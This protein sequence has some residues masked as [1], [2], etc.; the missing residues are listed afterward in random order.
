M[1]ISLEARTSIIE[2]VLGMFG[3]APGVNVLAALVASY[4]AGSSISQIAQNLANT[5][6]FKT[7]YPSFLSDQEY[8]ARIVANLAG[9]EVAD[10][11]KLAATTLLQ[12]MLTAGQSRTDVLLAA[13]TAVSAITSQNASWANVGAAFD[14]KLS[15]AVYY[16]IAKQLSGASLAGLQSIVANVTSAASTVVAAK[17][18]IDGKAVVANT[19]TLTSSTDNLT[20][21]VG[22]DIFLANT[23]INQSTG[24]V[25][26][27]TLSALDV[28]IG[29]SGNDTLLYSTVG[30]DAFPGATIRQIESLIIASDGEVTANL[31]GSN[32]S[33]ITSVTATAIGGDVNVD[34]NS[35][36]TTVTILGTASGVSI[37]DEGDA[38]TGAADDLASVS[39]TGATGDITIATDTLTAL[40]LNSTT[41]GDVAVNSSSGTR[42]LTI[43]L[44]N[45]SGPA[46]DVV[47]TDNQAT[48]VV[49]KST[50]QRSSAVDLQMDSATNLAF[51]AD[52]PVTI[53]NI[54][55]SAA[56]TIVLTGDSLVTIE[57]VEDFAAVTSISSLNSTGGVSIA[58]A[59]PTG[60][61]FVGGAGADTIVLTPGTTKVSSMGQ[62][63]DTVTLSGVFGTG[64]SVDAGAG[65]DTLSMTAADAASLSATGLFEATINGFE[66]VHIGTVGAGAT[67]LVQLA[68]LDDINY[69]IS[70]GTTAPTGGSSETAT[71]VFSALKIGQSASAGGMT[72][73]ATTDLSAAALALAFSGATVAG[74]TVTGALSGYSAAAPSGTGLN[75]VVLTSTTP[76]NVVN[77]D[78]TPPSVTSI[79]AP[80]APVVTTVQGATAVTESSVLV[81]GTLA[82]TE[83]VTV[84]GRT[85]TATGTTEAAVVTVGA[86]TQGQTLTIAG[87][88]LTMSNTA[89][90]NAT[91][92]QVAAILI[93]GTGVATAQGSITVSGALTGYSVAAGTG[94]QV[95][96]TSTVTFSDVA[97]LTVSGTGSAASLATA[98]SITQGNNG[99]LT[100]TQVASAISTG[101]SSGAALVSGTL[102]LTKFTA[103]T[104]SANSVTFTSATAGAVTDIVVSSTGAMPTITTTQ[105]VTEA[106]ESASVVM[107]GLK[108]G[109]S[110]TIH[111]LTLTATGADLSAAQVA[112][113]L[114]GDTAGFA[115][116]ALTPLA[117]AVLTGS[118]AAGFAPAA[119]STGNTVVYTHPSVG[120]QTDIAT[121]VANIVDATA[122]V[123]TISE[124]GV[125]A[126]GGTT[127]TATV[128]FS[129]LRIGQS[130]S[131]GGM[132]V[133][134][135]TDL[136]AAALAS[137]FSGVTVTGATVT[138]ALSGYSAAAP[139][140]A[141]L[142]TVVFTSATPG[143]VVNFDNTPPSVTSIAAPVAPV[144][145]TVQGATAV[146]ESSA[147]VFGTLARTEAVTVNGRTITATGTTE[148]A[149]VTVG[150]L[151]QGQ[152]LTI[153]GRTLTMSNTAGDNATAAQVAAILIS[154]T[155]AATAQ[156]SITVS[157]AL[158]GYSAAA[159]SGTQ[160]VFT[161]TVTFSDVADLTVSGTGSAASLATAVSITQGNNGTLTGTQVASAVSTGTSSGAA[162]VSGTLDLTKFTA[163]TSSANNVTFTSATAGAVTDI[164][165]SSTGAMPTITT[166]QGVTASV[167][168][169]SVVMS[170]L[171]AGQSVTIHGL[172]LTATGADLSA[173]QVAEALDG[174]TAGF[175][176]SALTPLATA[177]LTGSYAAGFAP[178]A[179]STGN[180][181]V[182]THPSVGAQTDIATS[183]ANIADATAPVVTISEGGV[184]APAAGNLNL[185]GFG[186][187]G[188][189]ELKGAINGTAT[190]TLANSIGATDVFNLVLNGPDQIEN[191]GMLT[192]AGVE[193]VRISAGDSNADAPTN[194][195]SGASKV[196]LALADTTRIIVTGNHGIDFT[197]S[198]LPNLVNLDASGVVSV[199]DAPGATDAAIAATGKVT[200]TSTVT[201]KAVSVAT[202][203]GADEIN[204]S[205]ITNVAL[206]TSAATVATI[207]AGA[208]NDVITGSAGNDVISGGAGADFIKG[209]EGADTLSGGSGFDTFQ[210]TSAVESTLI[211]SDQITDFVANTYGNGASGAAGTGAGNVLLRT[212]D[213]LQFRV[214]ADAKA[215]GV[216]TFVGT[217]AA[218][219]LSFIQAAAIDPAPAK[220]NAFV[221]ALDSS[222]GRLYID[223]NSDGSADSVILLSGVVTITAAAFELIL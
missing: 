94:T 12:S 135:T 51:N 180:T 222:T 192:I 17:A 132:T 15:V 100:G 70:D 220:D 182:Y 134:A 41:D 65:V 36:V 184:G 128:V 127:E 6:E 33:G 82:R 19:Y 86:L 27:E 108:A 219:A 40:T 155:G 151:T 130:A 136:S 189:L 109:Q 178:A 50:G 88:T 195:P 73:T 199:G 148:A 202:G 30:G 95:V 111:G 47:I 123:V 167:E 25:D 5:S 22:D 183:V 113:A 66:K 74:A 39:I 209:G 206:V 179:I 200:F 56:Q 110:V 58:S 11:E 3:A 133:T 101:T 72:V 18:A 191:T 172:T 10:A 99:T 124:G 168:S 170:G 196:N 64:G 71:V 158:T 44:N 112:E 118:Y 139:S 216:Y 186:A 52:E 126:V 87:R 122:P 175:A 107:S 46:T 21:G 198:T 48:S 177:V 171:K 129:A 91:A 121:S 35:N 221:A 98:V 120:A 142:T 102:D 137:A 4:E 53:S 162:V 210:Y 160:V 140:G 163:G 185:T 181:V 93:S 193:T 169:A 59:L 90:D 146:T 76:G 147:L 218:S 205:S 166:T 203:N 138:G 13:I 217:S 141:G 152:T 207:D 75:I 1:T 161:S 32:V 215:D 159:G 114:D 188:T 156:G 212:G 214:S 223:L 154:G 16:S 96:F 92:A 79:A 2:L 80:V 153:A 38:L 117:T 55:I 26:I 14:N 116:S 24:K 23:V 187:N 97:D 125:G 85:I 61:I 149:V 208:G 81:F 77:F 34:V 145:T 68:N 176:G 54:D 115:G 63:N 29:G 49:V 84:N 165:V 89:G 78:N 197:G 69:A 60:T 106:A 194:N 211:R 164:V 144:V 43:T 37:T 173:A 131:A 67:A 83:A 9:Q 204:V 8:A 45:V 28:L 57:A 42:T 103:G 174:D 150:A 119:I 31:T 143:N 20:G 104:S 7:L 201:S 157:G 190:V 105:G 62:G 213:V